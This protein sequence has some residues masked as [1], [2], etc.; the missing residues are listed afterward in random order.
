MDRALPPLVEISYKALQ[1]LGVVILSGSIKSALALTC[2]VPHSYNSNRGKS[3]WSIEVRTHLPQGLRPPSRT[4]VR[5]L[6]RAQERGL[7]IH[8]IQYAKA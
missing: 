1:S 4:D 2:E 8:R 6:N 5:H 3:G 7:S